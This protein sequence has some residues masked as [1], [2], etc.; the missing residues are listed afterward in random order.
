MLLAK[1]S[2]IVCS[3][4]WVKG[5][6]ESEFFFRFNLN[7]NIFR[8][9]LNR[10]FFYQKNAKN[11][12]KFCKKRIGICLFS[13]KPNR[14]QKKPIQVESDFLNWSPGLHGFRSMHKHHFLRFCMQKFS[15]KAIEN[16]SFSI[17][18]IFSSSIWSGKYVP[19]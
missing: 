17:F 14:T 19:S 2:F 10:I 8:F 11:P 9:K 6:V 15:E 3:R 1:I 18:S 13:Q 12:R 7:R 4:D 5:G 16:S